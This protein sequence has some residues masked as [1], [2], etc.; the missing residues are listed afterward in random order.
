MRV[1]RDEDDVMVT[2]ALGSCL[3][4]AVHD[5]VAR[6]GGLLHVMMPEGRTNPEKAAANPCIFVDTGVPALLQEVVN[7][8]GIKSRFIVKVAGG[9]N[10]NGIHNDRFQIGKRNYVTLRKILWKCGVLIKSEDVGGSSA[11]TMH[12]EIRDG[13]VRILS[14]GSEQ[15]L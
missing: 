2:H 13:R 12:L 8:G 14:A 4:I 9:A 6:V 1:S 11:R 10:V 3:G 15:E 5:P 7:A